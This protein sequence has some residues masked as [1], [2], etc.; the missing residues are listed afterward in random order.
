MNKKHIDELKRNEKQ[1]SLLT[2]ELQEAIQEAYKA[3]AAV[4]FWDGQLWKS[5]ATP[6]WYDLVT[7]RIAPDWQPEKD[8][9]E[10][11]VLLAVGHGYREVTLFELEKAQ[12]HFL[13]CCQYSMEASTVNLIDACISRVKY[14]ARRK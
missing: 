13:Q 12:A 14:L 3:G 11:T 8:E 7:Y 1:F 5:E 9:V 10:L 2:K 6:T 4:D